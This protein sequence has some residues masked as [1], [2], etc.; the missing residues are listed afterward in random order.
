MSQDASK[1]LESCRQIHRLCDSISRRAR[2]TIEQ[3]RLLHEEL[4]KTK[5]KSKELS[6][7]SRQAWGQQRVR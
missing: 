7:L 5:S 4:Q 1:F 6:M 3:S 2:E